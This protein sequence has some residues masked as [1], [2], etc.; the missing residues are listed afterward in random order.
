MLQCVSH[1][2]LVSVYN[3][4]NV[5]VREFDILKNKYSKRQPKNIGFSEHVMNIPT[6]T[7][8]Y[9]PTIQVPFVVSR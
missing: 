6:M 1:F 7:N 8:L 5:Q 3:F 9:R 4:T 2:M